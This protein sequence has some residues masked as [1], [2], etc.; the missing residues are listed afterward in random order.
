[1]KVRYIW[2]IL[3]ALSF[4]SCDDSTKSLG[5]EMFPDTDQI[6][7]T[8]KTYKASSKSVKSGP[9]FAKSDTVYVGKYTDTQFGEYEASFLTQLHCP[10]SLRF[11]KQYNQEIEGKD[12]GIMVGDTTLLTEVILYYTSFLGDTITPSNISIYKLKENLKTDH[13]TT[14]DVDKFYSPDSLLA[15]ATYSGVKLNQ[16]NNQRQGSIRFLLDKTVG[17]QILRLNRDHPDYFNSDK[18]FVDNVFKGIY[19]KCTSGTGSL[20][21]ISDIHLNVVYN[22][23]YVDSLGVALKKKNE[24]TDSIYQAAKTFSATR[25]I[26]QANNLISDESIIDKCIEEEGH[27]YVKSPAGIFTEIS[28]PIESLLNDEEIKN[29]TI[30]NVKLVLQSFVNKQTT[31]FTVNRPKYLALIKKSEYKEFFEKNKVF[32]NITSFYSQLDRE[33]KYSYNNLERLI[34]NLKQEKEDAKK[35]AQ[36]EAGS[37]WDQDKWEAEWKTDNEDWGKVY[38]IPVLLDRNDQGSIRGVSHNLRP[39]VAKIKGGILEKNGIPLDMKVLFTSYDPE[40]NLK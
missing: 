9:V 20:L 22:A 15:T 18:A 24:D 34:I 16:E 2:A 37:N 30:N 35:Q 36:E 23:H 11:P 3:L 4:T 31:T 14:I 27:T 38:L 10:D 40:M 19:A 6:Q 28:L 21:F 5:L 7:V 29:D 25:E 33:G 13:Y 12:K 17:E 26:V 8:Y 1:M 39:E 32:N